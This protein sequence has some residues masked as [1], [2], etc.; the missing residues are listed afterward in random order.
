VEVTS[1]ITK[2]G[3][4][5]SR[6]AIP[7]GITMTHAICNSENFIELIICIKNSHKNAIMQ[8]V[9]SVNFLRRNLF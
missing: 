9:V 6:S 2:D 4:I 7:S 3:T 5:L 8:D 1:G